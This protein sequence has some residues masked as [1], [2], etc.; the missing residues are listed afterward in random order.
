MKMSGQTDIS[1]IEADCKLEMG[2][3]KTAQKKIS[4]IEARAN[5]QRIDREAANRF[6]HHGLGKSIKRSKL[7]K[8][9]DLP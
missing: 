2:R 1:H 9:I 4:E 6:I 7:L 5:M 3:I 8:S